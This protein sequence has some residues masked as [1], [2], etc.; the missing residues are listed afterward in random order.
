VVEAGL[1]EVQSQ[2]LLSDLL[3]LRRI[4]G[5]RRAARPRPRP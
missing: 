2:V 1:E 5:R 3:H 4:F